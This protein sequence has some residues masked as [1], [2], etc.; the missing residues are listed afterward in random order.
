M[1][2]VIIGGG[3]GGLCLAQG[4]RAEGLE[5]E[6]HERAE[7]RGEG[8]AGYGI[9]LNADGCR[10]LHDCLPAPAW[11]RLDAAATPAPDVVRFHDER[12]R[13]LAVRDREHLAAG[14]PITRRRGI[15]RV[16][17]RE[18]L[19]TGLDDTVRWGRRFTRY[20]R[21]AGGRVRAHFA[22]GGHTDGDLLVAADGRDLVAE[23][24]RG[25]SPSV[26]ALV[27]RTDPATVA[28]VVLRGV[29]TLT[30][31]SPS[32][33]TLLGDAVHAMTPM[34]GV[35]ANTA[36]RDAAELRRALLEVAGGQR[37]LVG[38][39]G[40]Y[41]RRMRGYANEA[42]TLS[43]RNARTAGSDARLPRLAF[44][45]LLR[46][47]EA[48]PPMGRAVFPEPPMAP[49]GPCDAGAGQARR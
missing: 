22:D 4:L 16:A 49:V 48:V 27:A 32:A 21:L 15:G 37:D 45:T 35:G 19:L 13:P 40:R 42:L 1:R 30:E 5:V 39:V 8:L 38:A 18:A 43:T 23:R 2:T 44:R 11:A 6:V 24:L 47:A 10:A 12:L 26:R 20:E 31:W 9:H 34:A 29:P 33:V 7:D 17:L 41:E 28:P 46:L 14:D 3:V 36:L 25:W